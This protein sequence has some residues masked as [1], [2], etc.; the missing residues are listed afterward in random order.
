MLVCSITMKNKA[1]KKLESKMVSLHLLSENL[2]SNRLVHIWIYLKFVT[3]Y[4]QTNHCF[5]LI[6][7]LSLQKLVS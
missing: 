2:E 7:F 4:Y 1:N 5:V 6:M 3:L